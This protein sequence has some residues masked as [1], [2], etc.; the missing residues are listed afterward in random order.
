LAKE[1]DLSPSFLSMLERGQADISLSRFVRLAEYF[2]IRASDLLLDEETRRQPNV[3]DDGDGTLIDRGPGVTYRLLTQDRSG[4]QVVRVR[5]EPRA[6]FKDMLVHSG[7]D[8]CWILSGKLMLLYG[9][10][11]YELHR[12]QLVSYEAS[13]PHAFSNESDNPAEL[14]G[15]VTPAY[16]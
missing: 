6:R 12:G 14:L 4:A 7:V 11:E 2:G 9:D 10:H 16:W 13:T 15:F 3:V 8:F 5:F 1:V